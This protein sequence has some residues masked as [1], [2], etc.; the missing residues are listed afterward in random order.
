MWVGKKLAK[1]RVKGVGKRE[2]QMLKVTRKDKKKRDKKCEWENICEH[3]LRY[4]RVQGLEIRFQGGLKADP[5]GKGR[6][7]GEGRGKG[8]TCLLYTSDAADDWL[9]V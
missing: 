9:V 1:I 4:P 8:G 6:F 5:R 2:I 3:W 7:R